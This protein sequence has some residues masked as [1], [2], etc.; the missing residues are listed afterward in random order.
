MADA[1]VTVDAVD[2]LAAAHAAALRAVLVVGLAVDAGEAERTG[3]RVAV[4]VLVA[5][6]AV[7]AGAGVALVDVHLTV[8]A[9]EAVHAQAA[10]VAD[11][12]QARA[13]VVA[14]DCGQDKRLSTCV[15]TQRT[16]QLMTYCILL[17][18]FVF[19]AHIST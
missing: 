8:L 5:R 1:R 3:A 6:G 16:V 11:A 15:L 14:R 10:V 13:P 17:T 7:V 19:C 9:A 12:V 4:D 18:E 2:T